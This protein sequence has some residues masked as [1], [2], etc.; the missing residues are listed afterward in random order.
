MVPVTGP[1]ARGWVQRIAGWLRR[2]ATR[3]RAQ[4]MGRVMG[5]SLPE[6]VSW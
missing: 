6:W 1:M 5:L 3:L 2:L 4:K